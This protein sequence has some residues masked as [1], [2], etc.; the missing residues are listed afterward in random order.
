MVNTIRGRIL[1]YFLAV[2]I[3]IVGIVGVTAFSVSKETIV[4][5]AKLEGIA[6]A[7]KL[8]ESF[9]QYIGAR[10]AF[11]KTIAGHD[12]MR[13][14]DWK[15]AKPFLSSLDVSGLQI[16]AFFLVKP[17]G[18]ALYVDGR[19]G[20]LGDR[21]YFKRAV[22]ER[23]TIVGDPLLSR[24]TGEMVV[25]IASPVINSSGDICRCS[26]RKDCGERIS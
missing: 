10:A 21:E 13:E 17:D 4:E 14:G 6:I 24:S 5:G 15:T 19:V 7:G 11:L 26:L 1:I 25:I 16:Q 18:E 22:S 9:D 3:A 20:K 2:G 8:Q 23:R 12:L